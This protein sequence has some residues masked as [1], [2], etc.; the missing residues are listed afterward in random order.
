MASER[1]LQS[2]FRKTILSNYAACGKDLV[3]TPIF[4][5]PKEDNFNN[6]ISKSNEIRIS[7]ETLLQDLNFLAEI[8]ES[9]KYDS[10]QHLE[11]WMNQL[12]SFHDTFKELISNWMLLE[13]VSFI[14]PRL[15]SLC[16]VHWLKVL[17]YL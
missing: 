9:Q 7:L 13:Y 17:L 6:A 5:V 8:S 3:S 4:S 12:E 16:F 10:Q 1:K 11:L 2:I 15:F 14:P